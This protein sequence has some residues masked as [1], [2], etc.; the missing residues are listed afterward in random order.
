MKMPAKSVLFKNEQRSADARGEI[1][2]IVDVPVQN[3]SIITSEP[4]TIRSN[5]LHH[6]DFHLM[7]VLEGQIDYFFKDV[8]TGEINYI[9]VRPGDNIFTPPKELHSTYF[10]V[11][12]TLICS[13]KNPRDQETYEKDTVREALITHDNIKSM[14]DRYAK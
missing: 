12:T 8:E 13:S 14:L 2:S 7:Y 6:D 5:H 4:N 3:V 9:C 1:L 11:K 10:P